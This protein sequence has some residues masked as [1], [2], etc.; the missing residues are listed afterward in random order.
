MVNRELL[1]PCGLYCGVCAV[2]IAHRDNNLK[3]KEKLTKVYGCSAEQIACKGCMSDERFILCQQCPV[4]TC[5]SDKGYE[6]CHQCN[7]FPCEFLQNFPYPV[8]K[9]VIARAIPSWRELGTEQWVAEEEKRYHC[10]H[11]GYRLFRGARRCRSCQEPV[12]LD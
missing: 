12:D 5:V 10:P 4:R 8:G 9:K 6:G 1:A 7:D 11:C 2:L 3:F